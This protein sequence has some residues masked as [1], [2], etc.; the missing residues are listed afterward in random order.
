MSGIKEFFKGFQKGMHMFGNNVGHI[1]N[2]ALLLL[3]YVAGVGIT[4]IIAKLSGKRFLDTKLSEKDTYWSELD[5]K[6]K[7]EEEYY[8]QF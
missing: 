8:R 6:K 5:L 4:S 2:S 1:V 3:V 7:P